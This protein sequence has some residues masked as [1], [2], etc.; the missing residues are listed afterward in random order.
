VHEIS[1]ERP[2]RQLKYEPRGSAQNRLKFVGQVLW[3]RGQQ[4]VAIIEARVNKSANQ[5]VGCI[6]GKGTTDDP[7]LPEMEEADAD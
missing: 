7:D 1:D 5:R 2:I 6:G 4:T 3:A